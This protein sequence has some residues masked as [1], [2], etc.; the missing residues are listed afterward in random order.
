MLLFRIAMNSGLADRKA[1]GLKPL[2]QQTSLSS[3]AH[4]GAAP[5]DLHCTGQ[6][7]STTERFVC[8]QHAVAR[9]D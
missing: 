7:F 4:A 8:Y 3:K 6:T 1:S 9:S 5:H 2:P